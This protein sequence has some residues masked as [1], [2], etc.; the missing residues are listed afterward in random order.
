MRS[1]SRCRPTFATWLPVLGT[2]KPSIGARCIGDA[3]RED[4]LVCAREHPPTS[5]ALLDDVVEMSPIRA[6]N[7]WS[8]CR[9]DVA[10]ARA[11]SYRAV[12]AHLHVADDDAV[13]CRGL[14]HHPVEHRVDAH[15][16]A[17]GNTEA[18]RLAQEAPARLRTCTRTSTG[19]APWSW[20]A[21][22]SSVGS[23]RPAVRNTA[24]SDEPKFGF[25]PYRRVT[26]ALH[27]ASWSKVG[28][29]E[30]GRGY[31]AD[32]VASAGCSKPAIGR[33]GK[34]LLPM[35]LAPAWS[36]GATSVEVIYWADGS[37]TV[38]V[39]CPAA[40]GTLAARRCGGIC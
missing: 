9:P 19:S 37:I 34:G 18:F 11:N 23:A 32:G 3:F 26:S 22:A 25:A 17:R 4:E 28:T 8:P 21:P 14:G 13:G 7:R 29:S 5:N 38:Y 31:L 35:T 2:P 33:E 20:I 40:R 24:Y 10:R 39:L 27:D 12:D 6:S 15:L 30:I 16:V 36:G 1:R